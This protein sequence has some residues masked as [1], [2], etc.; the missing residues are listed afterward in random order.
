MAKIR[1]FIAIELP[2]GLKQDADKL[3]VTLKPI[4]EGV[5][6]VRAANLH[7]TLRFLGDIGQDQVAGLAEKL[8][9]NLSP[10]KPFPL[11]LSGLGC[12]PNMN[13]PRVIWLGGAGDM[14]AL[15]NLAYQV[16]SACRDC[17]L[18]KADKKFS[19]HLTIGRIKNPRGLEPF[20][21]RLTKVDFESD[22][23]EVGEVVIFKSDLSPRGPTYT[24]MA[25]IPIG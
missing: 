6:W 7:F 9:E 8:R 20:I 3:I 16:E 24:P 15:Q 10:L 21:E 23:F 19:A 18:G 12:F 5:R 25:K 13:R 14:E 22:E 4:A 11:K 17:G 2:S 1:T